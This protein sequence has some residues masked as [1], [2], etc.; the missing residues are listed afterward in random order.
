MVSVVVALAIAFPLAVLAHRRRWVILPIT[1]LE[2]AL[3]DPGAALISLLPLI[4][5]LSL[6]TAVIPLISYNLL[7]LFRNTWL[8]STGSTTTCSRPPGAWDSKTVSR[9]GGCRSLW[10]YR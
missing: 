1:A 10:R 5:G 9:S 6:T 4:T 8:G 7:I 2:R 3:H